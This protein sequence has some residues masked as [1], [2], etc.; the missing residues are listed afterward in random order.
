M[1]HCLREVPQ[2]L[3][4]VVAASHL[5]LAVPDLVTVLGAISFCRQAQVARVKVVL[6]PFT[7]ESVVK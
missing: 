6:Y 7:A 2:R 1:F 5:P 4:D 3:A